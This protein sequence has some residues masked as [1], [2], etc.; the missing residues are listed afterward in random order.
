MFGRF[1]R[2][3]WFGFAWTLI[4]TIPLTLV[5]WVWAQEQQIEERTI[6]NVRV[7]FAH[8]D[9][10]AYVRRANVTGNNATGAQVTVTLRGPRATLAEAANR[11]RSGLATPPVVELRTDARGSVILDLRRELAGLRAFS[12]GGLRLIDASPSS[13]EV[14]IEEAVESMIPVRVGGPLDAGE[15]VGQPTLDPESVELLGPRSL[16]EAVASA[17]VVA[18]LPA[19][20][21]PGRQTI[22]VPVTLPAELRQSL[23]RR[24]GD[25]MVERLRFEPAQVSV[26]FDRRD[27]QFVEARL[28]SVP[29]YVDKPA[30][31]EGRMEVR[32]TG[33][34]VINGVTVRGP[35][36]TIRRMTEGDLR[37]TARARLLV[38]K[39]DR[40]RVGVDITRDV[41]FELPEG[42]EVLGDPRRVTFRLQPEAATP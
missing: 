1:D 26:T 35:A 38:A 36:E 16:V 30:A 4:Y 6:S 22:N 5:L 14:T 31:M 2:N 7:Q 29:I 13:V 15:L 39:E 21:E 12:G 17:G 23:M 9:Q 40:D 19:N 10:Q 24:F 18:S 34:S 37:E 20:P 41:T 11:L 3:T 25:T 8:A 27:L 32:L 28:G 42:V 33:T